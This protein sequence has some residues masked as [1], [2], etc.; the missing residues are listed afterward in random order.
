MEDTRP[1]VIPMDEAAALE[2]NV[3]PMEE[4]VLPFEEALPA[5]EELPLEV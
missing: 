1:E 3:S 4:E 2:E 5:A